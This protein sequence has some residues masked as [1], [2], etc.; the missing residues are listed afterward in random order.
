MKPTSFLEAYLSSKPS[1][2]ID[3]GVKKDWIYWLPVVA[4]IATKEEVAFATMEELQTWC[5]VAEKKIELMNMG[6]VG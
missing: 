6:G 2:V 1:N 3:Q 5:S 4:G